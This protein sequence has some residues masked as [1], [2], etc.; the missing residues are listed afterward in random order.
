[1][2][3]DLKPI[4][5]RLQL[6]VINRAT[7]FEPYGKRERGGYDCSCGCAFFHPLEGKE[8]MDW[9]VCTNPESLRAGLLTF[10]HYGCP[11]FEYSDKD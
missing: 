7:D 1:M 9:G 8:G 6:V 10:E 4:N 5:E 2:S 3:N 11:H